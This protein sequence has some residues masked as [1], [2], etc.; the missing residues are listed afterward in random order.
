MLRSWR[1]YVWVFFVYFPFPEAPWG[2]LNVE[3]TFSQSK[4]RGTA[5]VAVKVIK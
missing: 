2:L 3:G 5:L 4:I 1:Y